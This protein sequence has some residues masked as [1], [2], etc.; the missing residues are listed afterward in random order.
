MLMICVIHM[1]SFTFAHTKVVPGKE[2]VYYL[3]I[4]TESV[5][6]IGV[7]L[8]A[9]ITGYVCVLSKWRYTR[10]FR[11]WVLVSFY[12]VA[13]AGVGYVLTYAGIT[14]APVYLLYYCKML[15]FGSTYWYFVAYTGLF[16]ITP[17]LN[18]ALKALPKERY[19]LMLMVLI[20][21][22]PVVNRGACGALFSMGYNMIWL[23]VMYVVGAYIK[24]YPPVRYRS[25][26]LLVCALLC[27]FVPLGL[28]SVGISGELFSY[29]MLNNVLYS[30]VL[31]IVFTRLNVASPKLRRMITL[32]APAAFSVYLIQCHPW[33]WNVFVS[34][35]SICFQSLDCPWW[36]SLV[37]GM[38]LY[39]AA[40]VID[41][42]RIA[43]FRICRVNIVADYI[44][45]R[46]ET[47]VKAVLPKLKRL[48]E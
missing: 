25:S 19:F 40:T 33:V 39:F 36:F 35:I 24:L 45:A 48:L 4:W 14:D 6:I 3:G 30:I 11:L 18:S 9:L 23:T 26:T 1:N 22:L 13:L 5:G 42:G 34:K 38:L 7:N 20:L 32:L 16:F 43:L 15:L 2:Y 17:C 29:S 31:F 47:A 28:T 27:S 21:L 8:Y 44:A 10:Y 37:F 41:F 46:I 12:T